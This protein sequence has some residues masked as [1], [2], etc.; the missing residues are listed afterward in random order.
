[1]VKKILLVIVLLPFLILMLSP[2][3]E[4][5]YLFEK[6]LANQGIIVSDGVISEHPF[7]LTIE[8]PALYFKG[9]KVA[10]AKEI[11]LWSVL[12]YTRGSIEGLVV[13]PSLKKYLPENVDRISLVHS[14]AS[15][16][17]VPVTLRDKTYGGEGEIRLKERILKIRLPHLP[18]KSPMMRYLKH[19]KGGWTYEQRF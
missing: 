2:K 15:P 5:F 10:T 3:K 12:A 8:H 1:M 9:A 14:I 7:G 17:V 4:I 13:D 11:T 19:T 16:F 18:A 6:Q